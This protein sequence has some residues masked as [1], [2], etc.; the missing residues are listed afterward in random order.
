MN[1]IIINGPVIRTR[2]KGPTNTRGSRVIA[3]HRRAAGDVLRAV[4]SWNYALSSDANHLAAAQL[5]LSRWSCDAH[6]NGLRIAA[7]G[8]D[9]TGHSFICTLYV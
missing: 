4:H 2:Y 7:R 5:L 3:E 9:A 1:E 8:Y 6:G